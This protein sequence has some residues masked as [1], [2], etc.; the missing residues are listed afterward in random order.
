MKKNCVPVGKLAHVRHVTQWMP[1]PLIK[2]DID[3]HTCKDLCDKKA[4]Q[5]QE[6]SARTSDRKVFLVRLGICFS[7]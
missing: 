1:W 3:T 5:L 4:V 6:G 7:I 2:M